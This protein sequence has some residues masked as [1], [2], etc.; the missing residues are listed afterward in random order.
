MLNDIAQTSRT[1][2]EDEIKSVYDENDSLLYAPESIHLHRLVFVDDSEA[3][4]ALAALKGGADFES[5]LKKYPGFSEVPSGDIGF[6]PLENLIPELKEKLSR[7]SKGQVSEVLP[8]GDTYQIF[9]MIEHRNAGKLPYNEVKDQLAQSIQQ[10]LSEET[11][12]QYQEKMKS[13]AKIE[14]NESALNKFGSN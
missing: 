7:L 2:T 10:K 9:K 11:I 12:F 8:I 5:L 6:L 4:I 14:I 3:E 13:G 1:P